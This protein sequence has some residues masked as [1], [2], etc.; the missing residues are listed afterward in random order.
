MNSPPTDPTRPGDPTPPDDTAK[1]T[2]LTH[3]YHA[4]YGPALGLA[5][6]A[7]EAAP[8]EAFLTW[9]SPLASAAERTFVEPP[10]S[11]FRALETDRVPICRAAGVPEATWDALGRL[12]SHPRCQAMLEPLWPLIAL[13]GRPRPRRA[14]ASLTWS[15]LLRYDDDTFTPIVVHATRPA[16]TAAMTDGDLATFLASHLDQFTKAAIS[17]GVDGLHAQGTHLGGESVFRPLVGAMAASRRQLSAALYDQL[18]GYITLCVK[19][20][21]PALEPAGPAPGAAPQPI[22]EGGGFAAPDPG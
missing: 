12:L 10:S 22:P 8:I 18:T 2:L 17:D 3:L 4:V 19:L 6:P 1:I 7:L 16:G 5:G 14:V 13:G 20:I 11:R 21:H 9:L 15:L